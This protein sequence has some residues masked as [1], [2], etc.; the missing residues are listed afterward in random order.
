[1]LWF[2]YP[3][4][5]PLDFRPWPAEPTLRTLPQGQVTAG[6]SLAVIGLDEPPLRPAPPADLCAALFGDVADGPVPV[7]F[8]TDHYC[9]N[10]RSLARTIEEQDGIS[11]V[12]HELPILGPG[13]VVAARGALAAGLQGEREAFH[14]RMRR[15]AFSPTPAYLQEVAAGLG[16]D[17]DRLLADLDGPTVDAELRRD[18]ALAASLGFDVVPV[19]VVGRT[20]VVGD[21]PARELSRLVEA[22]V[23]DGPPCPLRR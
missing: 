4:P 21:V 7:A 2:A 12:L 19:A 22:E 16:L 8:F 13:S 15:A 14:L 11:P 5:A 10:C 6:G 3:S 18:T 20:V 9:P 23:R 17:P 1:V